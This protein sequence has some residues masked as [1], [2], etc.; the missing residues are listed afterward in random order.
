MARTIVGGT[1]FS[2][3]RGRNPNA[4]DQNLREKAALDQRSRTKSSLDTLKQ[5]RSFFGGGAGFG[6]GGDFGQP[7]GPDG[8]IGSGGSGIG[9][10]GFGG[11]DSFQQFIDAAREA[12]TARIG[13]QSKDLL[14]GS[15]GSLSARG[16]GSSN[17]NAV[18][19]GITERFKG[20]QTRDLN[21]DLLGQQAKFDERVFGRKSEQDRQLMQFIQ[22]NMGGRG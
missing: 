22:S 3:L 13:Q 19:R 10:S 18:A 11:I 20:E 1:R 15:L 7:G 21:K 16:L 5:F 6:F 2:S 14:G 4:I 12:G 8:G 17:L 9:G